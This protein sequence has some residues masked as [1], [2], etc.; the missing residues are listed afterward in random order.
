MSEVERIAEQL[1]KTFRGPTWHGPAVEEVLRNVTPNVAAAPPPAGGAHSI[2]QIVA[3][4]TFW[5]DVTRSWL[6]GDLRQPQEEASWS[7]VTDTSES[8]WQATLGRLRDVHAQLLADVAGLSDARLGE[9]LFDDA[10]TLYVILHSVAQ[11]NV[12]H[13]GQIALLKKVGGGT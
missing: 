6:A 11:H 1:D 8:A 2:W 7:T 12:Y 3:H 4:M 9:R 5:E 10:P 13:A